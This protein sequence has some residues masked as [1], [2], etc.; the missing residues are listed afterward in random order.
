MAGVT[1]VTGATATVLG[2]GISQIDS[3]AT[4]ESTGPLASGDDPD[5]R[6]TARIDPA[7]S[8][9]VSRPPCPT[10]FVKAAG[11]STEPFIEHLNLISYPL[12][13]GGTSLTCSAGV[14]GRYRADGRLTAS[15]RISERAKKHC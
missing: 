8:P 3:A 5:G 10:A 13:S 12:S 6:G 14:R 1:A 9:G 7:M 15:R 2:D 11:L 4:T